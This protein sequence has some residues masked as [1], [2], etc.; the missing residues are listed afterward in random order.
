MPALNKASNL[1]ERFEVICQQIN[2]KRNLSQKDVATAVVL[3]VLNEIAD[4]GK[5][6]EF[7]LG[8]EGK[9]LRVTL[10]DNVQ[11]TFTAAKNYQN[12]YLA[13]SGLMPEVKGAG[14]TSEEFA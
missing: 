13:P 4:S 6:I 1:Y 10:R 3:T 8:D 12:S 14:T 9:Q 7:W 2:G 11:P 5:D